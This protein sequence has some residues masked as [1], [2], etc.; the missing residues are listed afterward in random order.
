MKFKICLTCK[1][2]FCKKGNYSK[3]YWGKQKY[4]SIKCSGTL[5][6]KGERRS[7]D[8]CFEEGSIGKL[9]RSYKGGR[10]ISVAGYVRVLIPGTG[11]YQLE[12]RLVMEKYLGR[13]LETWECIHHKNGNRQDNRIKNLEIMIKQKHDSYETRKRWSDKTKP[14]RSNLRSGGL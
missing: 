2:K 13:K 9:N 4:C 11:S 1:K 6:K 14:F 10:N 3:K 5:I 8:T 12:H 7:P